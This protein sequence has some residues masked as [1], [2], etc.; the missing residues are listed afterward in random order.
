LL[1]PG[2]LGILSSG[3]EYT[4]GRILPGNFRNVQCIYKCGIF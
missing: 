1:I 2:V 4:S 3:T